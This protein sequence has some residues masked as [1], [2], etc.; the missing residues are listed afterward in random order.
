MD[1]MET[2]YLSYWETKMFFETEELDSIYGLEDALSSHYDSTSPEAEAATSSLQNTTSASAVFAA[3]AVSSNAKNIVIERNRRKKLNEKLYSLR[4][5]VPNITKM[6]KASIIKDAIE[7][8][9]QLQEEEKNILADISELERKREKKVNYEEIDD[10]ISSPRKKNKSMSSSSLSLL[11]AGSS[12]AIELVELKVSEIGDNVLAIS[13][14]CNKKKDTM[15]R[16]CEVFESL[17]LNIITASLTAV[18]G[19]LLHT[20]FVEADKTTSAEM[21]QKIEA[22][23]VE[24][25]APKSPTSTMSF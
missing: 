1:D 5:V 15:A 17:N 12:S 3:S 6:D 21:K 25:D 22:A 4:S 9:Q 23:I 2:E 24:L 14:T 8:I 13:L 19:S 7:Y 11:Y 20:L 16:L 10:M 18:S